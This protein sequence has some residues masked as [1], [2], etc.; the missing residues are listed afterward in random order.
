MN[1]ENDS[2][3]LE[4][5]GVRPT[6]NRILILR[7]M[8]AADHPVSLPELEDIMET[9]DKSSIFRVLNVF[10]KHHV[11]HEI[12]DGSGVMKYEICSGR[13][14]CTLDDMHIH[15]YC[16]VCHRTFCFKTIHVPGIDLPRGFTVNSIN[17]MAKGV[18]PEC[19]GK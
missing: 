3:I 14:K 2:I 7:T 18:C 16:E 12:E 1:T 6:A 9:M 10:V 5:K 15:F 19:S 11:A 13:D 17:Y 8:L 4:R